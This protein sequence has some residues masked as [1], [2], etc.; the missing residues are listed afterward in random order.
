MTTQTFATESHRIHLFWGVAILPPKHRYTRALLIQHIYL[1]HRTADTPFF[2]VLLALEEPWVSGLVD[3]KMKHKQLSK[4]M[5][6]D[7]MLMD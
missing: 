7:S 1:L 6:A 5:Q 3:E 2:S 4:A